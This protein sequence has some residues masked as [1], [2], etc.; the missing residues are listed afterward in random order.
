[1]HRP[2]VH[3]TTWYGQGL[4]LPRLSR[5]LPRIWK[6]WEGP[7]AGTLQQL[8]TM[9]AH[10]GTPDPPSGRAGGHPAGIASAGCSAPEAP[11]LP[12][13][14]QH[15]LSWPASAVTPALQ[16]DGT[17]VASSNPIA[18][19]D[20]FS[21]PDAGRDAARITT[22]AALRLA[23]A[24]SRA[25]REWPGAARNGSAGAEGREGAAPSGAASSSDQ[26]LA[27]VR[28]KIA[29]LQDQHPGDAAKYLAALP[30]S[31]K[32]R[33]F[34]GVSPAQRAAIMLEM[35]VDERRLALSMLRPGER[36]IAERF[37]GI[38]PV[39]TTTP[40]KSAAGPHVGRP[41]DMLTPAKSAAGH[42]DSLAHNLG[43]AR[44]TDS[45]HTI[46][47]L[48]SAPIIAADFVR[49]AVPTG[50]EASPAA[51]LQYGRAAGG[52]SLEERLFGETA[53]PA[54]YA[55]NASMHAAVAAAAAINGKAADL[56]ETAGTVV[57]LAE[58]DKLNAGGQVVEASDPAG[59]QVVEAISPGQNAPMHSPPN[60]PLQMQ[61]AIRQVEGLEA[62][63][64][65]FQDSAGE[66]RKAGEAEFKAL[67][68]DEACAD[69]LPESLF[70]LLHNAAIDTLAISCPKTPPDVPRRAS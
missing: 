53:A 61:D 67:N 12:E 50:G 52:L 16:A 29:E 44:L 36:T 15:L 9:S 45:L 66:R 26:G 56:Y 63:V 22:A 65:G 5:V 27:E 24:R 3:A 7:K 23:E 62:H 6:F 37:L 19:A 2:S 25:G 39:G 55:T 64:Q 46:E 70:S 47:Q 18:G 54:L 35:S 32:W 69:C 17:V 28:V 20:V 48:V 13:N 8:D 14:G 31:L 59:G 11:V 51:S 1:M 21:G 30:A 57:S 4:A 33:C 40:S 58:G 60:A 34:L 43:H 10:G 49:K 41:P 42:V 68:D 38:T